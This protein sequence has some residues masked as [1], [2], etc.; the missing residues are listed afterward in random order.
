MTLYRDY[1]LPAEYSLGMKGWVSSPA[2]KRDWEDCTTGLQD[3]CAANGFLAMVASILTS[4]VPTKVP[5]KQALACR[6][7][8]MVLLREKLAQQDGARLYWPI[9]MRFAAE[10]FARNLPAAQT[11]ARM[12]RQC[13]EKDLASSGIVDIGMLT[14]VLYNDIQ[15]AAIFLVR[16]VFDV[17]WLNKAFKK[18]WEYARSFLPPLD[19]ASQAFTDQC[20]DSELLRHVFMMRRQG[21]TVWTQTS[22]ETISTPPVMMWLTSRN[23]IGQ[24][25]LINHYRTMADEDMIA[26]GA[27]FAHYCAQVFISLAALH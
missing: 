24:A 10:V 27:S 4:I 21:T 1:V 6:T 17:E 9:H 20:V 8:S 18:G 12:L 11:H 14:Q 13:F 2:A 5:E 16:P 15:L 23:L 26:E 22:S 3:K 19:A 7:I 25:M